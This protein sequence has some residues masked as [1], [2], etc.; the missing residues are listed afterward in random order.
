MLG[1]RD[2]GE[3]MLRRGWATVYEAKF[4]SEFGG[5]EGVYREMEERA[6]KRGVGM[7][8]KS[9]VVGRLLGRSGGVKESP[10]EYKTRMKEAEEKAA[11]GEEGG[12]GE[13]AHG[14]KKVEKKTEK[15]GK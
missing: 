3:E 7:W 11:R 4:G 1:K 2:V 15:R 5:R 13:V 14:E 6:R 12:K 9:G 10:R 8:A